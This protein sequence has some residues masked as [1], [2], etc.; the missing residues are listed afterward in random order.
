MVLLWGILGRPLRLG[1][2][3]PPPLHRFKCY[4]EMTVTRRRFCAKCGCPIAPNWPERKPC[5]KCGNTIIS[6]AVN[7]HVL[8]SAH[9]KVV[10]EFWEKNW[11][12]I[13]SFAVAFFVAPLV[14]VFPPGKLGPLEQTYILEAVLFFIGL[15]MITKVRE[16]R[17]G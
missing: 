2:S 14:P 17:S 9:F 1:K 11:P 8:I 13:V 3:G 6:A 12:A 16:I 15:I 7:A 5:P 4:E 10:H